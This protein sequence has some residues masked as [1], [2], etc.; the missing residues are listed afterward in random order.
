MKKI[1]TTTTDVEARQMILDLLDSHTDET[2]KYHNYLPHKILYLFDTKMILTEGQHRPQ[3]LFFQAK[4]E[5]EFEDELLDY[6]NTTDYEILEAFI[7]AKANAEEYECPNDYLQEL[8]TEYYMNYEDS[9]NC[10][11]CDYFTD[12]NEYDETFTE[13]MIRTT[14]QLNREQKIND[15]L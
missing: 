6:A 12:F 13:Y 5:Q 2:G 1:T 4:T 8:G 15:L 9:M 3:T 10:F 11:I 14:T 7:E